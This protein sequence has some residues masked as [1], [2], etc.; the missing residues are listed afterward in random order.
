MHVETI[1]IVLGILLFLIAAGMIADAVVADEQSLS[2]ERR[3]RERP[4]R[5]RIGQIV[6]G[7]GMLCVAAALIGRDQWRF[8]TLTIAAAVVLVVVG[9]G[10]NMRYIRGSL[11]GP[12]L[13]RS[14]RR[15]ETDN[16]AA[17]KKARRP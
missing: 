9:V 7:A 15:R 4:E 6:L 10:L 12:V 5:S 3:S 1:P 14:S 16:S 13:G 8:T 11:L 2:T 17:G